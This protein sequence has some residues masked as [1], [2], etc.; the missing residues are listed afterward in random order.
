[1]LWKCKPYGLIWF[2]RLTDDKLLVLR[3]RQPGNVWQR[4]VHR[5]HEPRHDGHGA[6]GLPQQY[7]AEGETSCV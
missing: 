4:A 6:Q 1:M 7:H 5:Q 3:A 2:G